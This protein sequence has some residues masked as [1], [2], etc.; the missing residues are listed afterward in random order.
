MDFFG[1]RMKALYVVG[2]SF[3]A[4]H[5]MAFSL[6]HARVETSFYWLDV[7]VKAGDVDLTDC[8]VET[9]KDTPD[10]WPANVRMDGFEYQRLMQGTGVRERLDWLRKNSSPEF[11]PQPFQQLAKVMGDL[12]HRIDRA[13]VLVAMEDG[14]RAQQRKGIWIGFREA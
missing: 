1:A 7:T 9:L 12:G 11:Q 2:A 3:K 6:Q 8:K 10:G 14:I 4:E 13:K 5:G